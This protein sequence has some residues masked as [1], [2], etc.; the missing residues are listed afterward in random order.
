MKRG[1]PIGSNV[2][3]NLIEIIFFKNSACGYALHKIYC[4]IFPKTS[5][6]NIYYNLRQGVKTEEFKVE[7]K[8]V[9]GNFSWGSTAEKIF[10]SLGPKAKPKGDPRV[11]AFFESKK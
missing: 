11:K 4:E 3:Q 10:Y 7:I 1:R 2:R 8:K 9:Q 6:E 5:R